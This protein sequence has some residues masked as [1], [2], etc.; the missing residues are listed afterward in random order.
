M[1]KI[2]QPTRL[3]VIKMALAIKDAYLAFDKE[4]FCYEGFKR[5]NKCIGCIQYE[6]IKTSYIISKKF[7]PK[8]NGE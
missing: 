4:D 5:C 7:L 1:G 2:T 3:Q 6:N 8:K